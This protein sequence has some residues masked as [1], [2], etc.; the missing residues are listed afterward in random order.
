MISEELPL[1][2]CFA[3]RHPLFLP[4]FID[5]PDSGAFYSTE[6]SKVG[7]LTNTYIMLFSYL[8]LNRGLESKKSEEFILPVPLLEEAR[9]LNSTLA[10]YSVKRARHF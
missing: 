10:P 7:V 9:S 1:G 8:R 6:R 3:E 4:E 5:T 2:V